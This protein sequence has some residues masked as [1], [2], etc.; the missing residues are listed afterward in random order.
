MGRIRK[1]LEELRTQNH[2][3]VTAYFFLDKGPLRKAGPTDPAFESLKS[4][5]LLRI[6]LIYQL[7]HDGLSLKFFNKHQP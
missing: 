6:N 4:E 2:Q 5:E 1:G 7:Y 3:K